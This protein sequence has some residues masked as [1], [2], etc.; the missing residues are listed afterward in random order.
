[1][2][3]SKRKLYLDICSY[4]R[5]KLC[6]LYD[7][8][9]DISGQAYDVYVTTQRNGWKELSFSIPS[10]CVTEGGFED[11]YRINFLKADFL[12][13][14][15][16]DDETDWFIISEPKI[17]HSA[18]SKTISVIAGHISQLLKMKN[19]GLEFSDEEGNNVG[20]AEELLTTILNGTG[21]KVGKV[22][23]FAEK[24]GKTKY[25]SLKASSKT[26]AFKLI[27]TMCELFDAKPIYHG[28]DKTVDIIPINPFSEPAP[29]ELPDLSLSRE[30]VELHYGQNV[31]NVAR[32]LNTENMVTK[33]YA[34]GAYGDKTSGYCGLDECEHIEYTYT[35]TRD[36]A[37]NTTYY[38]SFQDA[39][40]VPLV[41]HF[42][43][44]HF[45]KSGSRLIYSLLDPSSQ[46][47][48]WDEANEAAYLVERGTVGVNLPAEMTVDKKTKN[49]FQFVM[50]YDYY[51]K[52]GLLTDSMV[53]A[54]AHYQKTAPNLY[55]N[56]SKASQKMS[57][58]QT[59]LSKTIG[60]IDFCKLDVNREEPLLGD[61][62]TV[63][64]LNKDKYEDGV[65]YRSD[66]DK[67]KDNRFKWRV[68][69]SLNTD[70][71]PINSAAGI[72]YIIHNTNP[73]TW[74]KAYLKALDDE[75]DP[76]VLTLWAK[77]GSMRI[78]AETDQF[79]LFSYHGINGRLGTLESN[80]ESAVMSL[81]EAV[82][83]VTIEHPV[84]F[85]EEEPLALSPGVNGYGWLWNYKTDKTPSDFYFCFAD[86]GDTKWQLVYFQDSMPSGTIEGRYWFDWR[87]SVLYR[88]KNNAWTT[89][90]SAAQKKIAAL[91]PTVYMF[92]KARDRYYQGVYENYVY[93]VPDKQTL[94]AGNYF[95]KNEYQSYWTF[96]TTEELSAGDTLTYNYDRAW[97]M[98]VK[99]GT[100]S[101]LKPKGYRF[102]NV[103][104]HPYDV[105]DG[106]S[107][108]AGAISPIDGALSDSST[109]CRM[110]SYAP[111][112]PATQYHVDLSSRSIIVH[113]YDDKKRW[114][115]SVRTEN[116]FTTPGNCTFIRISAECAP[117][118]FST[119]DEM[120][121]TAVNASNTI[122]IEDLNYIKLQDSCIQKTGEII[123]LISCMDKF[124]NISN[125]T[126][127]TYYQ[128]LKVAQDAIV[129]LETTMMEAVGDL[130]REGWWNAPNY[131]DGDEGKLYAD[132]LDN[133]KEISKPEVTYNIN[134]LDRYVADS[135]NEHYAASEETVCVQWPD[136]SIVDAVHLIDPEI[137]VNTWAFMDKIQKCYDKPWKT[138]IAINT[139]LST[140]GQHSFT[141]VMTNIATVA[142]EMKGKTSYYDKTI[143]TSASSNT[144]SELV[145]NISK[146]EKELL[147]T[148]SRVEKIGDMV[149]THSS[150]LKRTENEIVAEVERAS[151]SDRKLSAQI[152]VAADGI[153][154]IV[155]Q[156]TTSTENNA[157]KGSKLQTSINQTAKDITSIVSMSG[158]EGSKFQGS[159]LQQTVK[160]LTTTVEN[161]SSKTILQQTPESILA[162]VKKQNEDPSA[163]TA[164]KT[165]SVSIDTDGV[166]IATDGR[167]SV[168]A[169]S[170]GESSA[171]TIDKNGVAIGSS[172]KFTVQ[173]DNFGVTKDGKI[174][175]N[176]AVINGQISNNGYPVL[177]RNYDLYVGSSE[178]ANKHEGMI[179]IQPGVPSG[180]SGSGEVVVPT[181]QPVTFTGTTQSSSNHWFYDQG[182]ASVNLTANRYSAG[183][184]TRAYNYEVTIPLFIDGRGSTGQRNGATFKISLN[185][186]VTLTLTK[187]WSASE[188]ASDLWTT[189]TLRGQSMVWLGDIPSIT[190][191]ISISRASSASLTGNIFLERNKTVTVKCS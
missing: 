36:C 30:V 40:D 147:G 76:S 109:S 177:T 133:L 136:I 137:A 71:D 119:F 191:T 139:K 85:T 157:Y 107:L 178:P 104:Y 173:T 120:T 74:D 103:S 6:P 167:F 13:R 60:Y 175:A 53:Q 99:N 114:I 34:Y 20:T 123:G 47:Y 168:S 42:T 8:H 15:I 22:Y 12:I 95:I 189:L 186:S 27:A 80:D 35:L 140:I 75:K 169:G 100:Q 54:I 108:E 41:Y 57:E 10:V 102:D 116:F 77:S 88:R 125:L 66:F 164:F 32:T 91:F 33:L 43:P 63:L 171:V 93:T 105:I 134:Y 17:T 50:N 23:P 127:G 135:N 64:I 19:L 31:T 181:N 188:S 46:M 124:A 67:N 2:Q 112:V 25:R 121:I 65:I 172:G 62:Y 51:R 118:D 187:E 18:Y 152:K 156:D 69:E 162:A 185:G 117:S 128:E 16:D 4:D 90:S 81:E 170:D 7:N 37:E 24:D 159:K 45:M 9:S 82:K 73:T 183:D 160:G 96:T 132:T 59:E 84:I 44:M 3:T 144:V 68:T 190:A 165:T 87:S 86:E 78:N 148:F 138:K 70:G 122:V 29:G 163:N 101:A 83:V 58:A 55:E 28:D 39:A 89:L 92:C 180:G 5:K 38:F 151:D 56:V 131:V 176:D 130:Y 26:G 49:W 1:M 158:E 110:Q 106:S 94:S 149:I 143:E 146:N 150:R 113:F 97:I 174:S 48:I 61:G 11:N 14:L 155:N 141:D 115:S 179:W 72:V 142:S 161:I 21:W 111:V 126:Y 154:S 79:F 182:A 129:A 184:S 166:E 52:A 145:A 98:Q 153:T